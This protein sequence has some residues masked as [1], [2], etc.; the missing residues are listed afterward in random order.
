MWRSLQCISL[1]RHDCIWHRSIAEVGCIGPKGYY[2]YDT[3]HS[4]LLTTF[5]CRWEFEN[6]LTIRTNAIASCR[7]ELNT[8]F[9]WS[10]YLL[11]NVYFFSFN[12]GPLCFFSSNYHSLEELYTS[13]LSSV[14][15]S[16]DCRQAQHNWTKCQSKFSDDS[17]KFTDVWC[18]WPGYNETSLWVS[19]PPIQPASST[20]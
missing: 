8:V 20:A 18:H 15:T 7:V 11:I 6:E 14:S 2:K 17:S 3:M 1:S 9:L 10:G 16:K 19:G 4:V 5:Y 12:S 13:R